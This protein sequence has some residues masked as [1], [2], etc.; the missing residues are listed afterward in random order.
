MGSTWDAN[1]RPDVA[2]IFSPAKITVPK[3]IDR[4]IP[5]DRP[6]I[7]SWPIIGIKLK[8]VNI[9]K[10]GSF[11]DPR[12]QSPNET[13]QTILTGKGT[14]REPKKGDEIKNAP[15]RS[16]QITINRR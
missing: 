6:I 12:T 7:I 15:T 11:V 1:A 13:E 10:L 4:A 14:I 16:V 2:A 8:L 9:S 5:A 3:H